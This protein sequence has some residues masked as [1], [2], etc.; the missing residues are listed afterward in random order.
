MSADNVI[1]VT[2]YWRKWHVWHGSASNWPTRPDKND[3]YY[4]KFNSRPAALEYAIDCV[5]KIGFV[6]Y[7]VSEL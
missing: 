7:G 6:E 1:F 4:K 2:K 5:K 3:R